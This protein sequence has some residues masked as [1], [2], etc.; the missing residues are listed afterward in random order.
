MTKTNKEKAQVHASLSF[1]CSCGKTGHGNGGR[2]SHRRAHIRRGDWEPKRSV[3][4]TNPAVFGFID[5]AEFLARFGERM[6]R[7]GGR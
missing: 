4:E 6:E 2:S 1:Y 7:D 3:R 5:R